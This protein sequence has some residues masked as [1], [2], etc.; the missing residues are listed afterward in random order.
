MQDNRDKE[1]ST[2]EVQSAREQKQIPVSASIF[3]PVQT[4]P[5]YSISLPGVKCRSGGFNHP[6]ASSAQVKERAELHLLPFT[7]WA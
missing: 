6:P 4:G 2:N 5:G 3:A 7:F 1:P